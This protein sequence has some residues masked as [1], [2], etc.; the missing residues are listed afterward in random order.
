MLLYQRIDQSRG[1]VEVMKLFRIL[2]EDD[3]LFTDPFDVV[4]VGNAQLPGLL[5]RGVR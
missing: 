2:I 3:R 5:V 1:G 4:I